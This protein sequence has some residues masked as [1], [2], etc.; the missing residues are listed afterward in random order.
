MGLTLLSHLSG[1]SCERGDTLSADLLTEG[2]VWGWDHKCLLTCHHQL[3]GITA[4]WPASKAM[5]ATVIDP[6]IEVFH[7]ELGL[8]PGL[9]RLL[10][11]QGRI[12]VSCIQIILLGLHGSLT[13]DGHRTSWGDDQ[14]WLSPDGRFGEEPWKET[15]SWVTKTFLT[16]S[17]QLSP[18]PSHFVTSFQKCCVLSWVPKTKVRGG[19]WNLGKAYLSACRS[20]DPDSALEDSSLWEICTWT[21]VLILFPLGPYPLAFWAWGSP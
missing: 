5:I 3:Q 8:V 7:D 21:S 1:L 20:S 2:K 13:P 4:L 6:W 9:K 17:S 15:R 19:T 12:Y 14:G 18:L 10:S 16:P 11:F